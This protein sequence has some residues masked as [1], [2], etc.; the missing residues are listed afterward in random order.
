[1]MEPGFKV[2]FIPPSPRRSNLARDASVRPKGINTPR[3]TR[4]APTKVF[5]AP[6]LFRLFTNKWNF[7]KL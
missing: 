4:E 3:R 7:W 5:A 2:K 1:M 6:A